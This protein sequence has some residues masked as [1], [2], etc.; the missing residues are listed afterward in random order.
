MCLSEMGIPIPSGVQGWLGVMGEVRRSCES[1][2]SGGTVITAGLP[3]I[4][5]GI[6][7][8]GPDKDTSRDT[9]AFSGRLSSSSS[10][11]IVFL[12]HFT[13]PLYN[14]LISALP[15]CPFL[16]S[17]LHLPRFS[18][19]TTLF[20]CFS[21]IPFPLNFTFLSSMF[22]LFHFLSLLCFSILLLN[23]FHYSPFHLCCFF[24][25]FLC[26]SRLVSHHFSS[27]FLFSLL[28]V[29][30]NSS[31]TSF[32]SLFRC[33]P[34]FLCPVCLLFSPPFISS[35]FYDMSYSDCIFD[36]IFCSSSDTRLLYSSFCQPCAEAFITHTETI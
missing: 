34:P 5:L 24:T 4:H 15:S 8:S 7:A 28:S 18:C 22:P 11:P 10:L 36:Y 6:W 1:D 13:F 12:F 20:I 14:L 31:L 3:A 17:S 26:F 35:H 9:I 21:I 16:F 30:L 2:W 19:H 27:P 33:F 29:S 25:F 23:L 32:S